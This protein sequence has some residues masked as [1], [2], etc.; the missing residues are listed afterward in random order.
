MT[1]RQFAIVTLLFGAGL[2]LA[3]IARPAPPAG[4][5]QEP[6]KAEVA[7]LNQRPVDETAVPIR[8]ILPS[9]YEAR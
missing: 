1:P 2:V 7:V 9:P 6:A 4:L 5:Q 3:G 8:V